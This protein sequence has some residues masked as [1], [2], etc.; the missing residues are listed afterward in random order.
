VVDSAGGTQ[1]WSPEIITSYK[2]LLFN[3]EM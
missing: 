2:L 1:L 3:R